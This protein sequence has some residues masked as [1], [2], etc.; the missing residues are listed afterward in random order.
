MQ[1]YKAELETKLK[2]I[3]EKIESL[4]IKDIKNS[5]ENRKIV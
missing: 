4:T 1:K 5:T 3:K 2:E